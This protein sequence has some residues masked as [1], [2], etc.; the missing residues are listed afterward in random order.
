MYANPLTRALIASTAKYNK[1]IQK[2]ED[3]V[4]GL[5]SPAK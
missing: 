3:K 1:D 2:E 4:T 5:S